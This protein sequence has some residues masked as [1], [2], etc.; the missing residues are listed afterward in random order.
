MEALNRETAS[1]VKVKW[2]DI[3]TGTKQL[4]L[5]VLLERSL[6]E[7]EIFQPKRSFIFPSIRALLPRNP[8]WQ[9]ALT[10]IVYGASIEMVRSSPIP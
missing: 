3:A 4:L 2:D 1:A 6:T 10:L 7:E 8:S 9:D 5:E